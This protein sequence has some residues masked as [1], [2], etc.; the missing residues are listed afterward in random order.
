M[1]NAKYNG[2]LHLL[3][4]GCNNIGDHG[5]EQLASWLSERPALKTLVLCRNII[6]NH[7]AR[8]LSYALPS[9]KLL[10]LDVSFNR[11]RDGGMVDILN[12]LKKS[13]LLRQLR[14]FGNCIGH[15]AAKVF[16]LRECNK[17]TLPFA[18]IYRLSNEC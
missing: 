10:S 1:S 4:L 5:V 18:M 13:P 16:V 7:G 17:P 11:I 8:E 2:T 6:T 12:T 3:D 14:I 15:P 9:S